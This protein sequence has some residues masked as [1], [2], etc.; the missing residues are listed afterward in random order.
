MNDNKTLPPDIVERFIMGKSTNSE[1]C[2]DVIVV[3]EHF[4]AVIDGVTSKFPT[5]YEGKAPGRYCAELL[6]EAILS[7]DKNVTAKEALNMLN[8]TVKKAY[9]D[10]EITEETKMQACVIIYS[11]ARREIFNY[12]D[13]QLMINGEQFDH[14]K[15][16]DTLLEDLRAFTISAYL[17]QGGSESDIYKKDI[18]REAILPFLKKQS[19]FANK[20]G[21]FGYAVIDGTDINEMLIKSYSL[22]KGDRVVLASDG[23]PKLFPTLRESEDYLAKVLKFDPLAINENKQTKMK[24]KESISF[25]DRSYLSFIVQ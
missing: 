16:I 21:Y 11:K 2:E 22:T 4:Y 25:D 5:K 9:G 17:S 3:G 24:S 1:Q 12:G 23:Y 18:G 13:C 10:T 6:A 15:R 20:D 8:D 19:I 14:T 7:L